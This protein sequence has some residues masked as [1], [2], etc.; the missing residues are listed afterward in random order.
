MLPDTIHKLPES[1]RFAYARVLAAIARSDDE[2]TIEEM[3]M[4]EQRLGTA[5]LSP[6]QRNVIRQSLK[7]DPIPLP[8]LLE[9]IGPEGGKLALRD[10]VMMAAVDGNVD[11]DERANL[12]LIAK[13]L[14]ISDESV[15]KLLAWTMNGYAWMQEGFDLLE[16]L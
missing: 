14:G 9:D 16:S 5:L 4:F 3:A 6:G 15:E 2:I 10:A 12:D 11:D 7:S 13:E 1:E 8:E